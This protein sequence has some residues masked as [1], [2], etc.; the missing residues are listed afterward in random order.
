MVLL[1]AAMTANFRRVLIDSRSVVID[2]GRETRLFTAEARDAAKLLFTECSHPGCSVKVRYA[3]VDH[4]DE[5]HSGGRTDQRNSN[6]E[7]KSHN[8]AKHRERWRTRRD[9]HGRTFTI[10]PD[11]SVMLPVGARAPD[12]SADELGR[13]TRQRVADLRPAS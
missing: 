5:W 10:R 12:L 7:C 9:E 3:E 13:I 8:R 11:G 1:K 2:R 4:V 6:I